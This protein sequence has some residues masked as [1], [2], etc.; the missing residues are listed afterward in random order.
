MVG[1]GIAAA[2]P[3]PARA[4]GSIWETLEGVIE[5]GN[6]WEPAD[7]I[8]SASPEGAADSPFQRAGAKADV[9]LDANGALKVCPSGAC[10]GARG[11]MCGL[12]LQVRRHGLTRSRW[13]AL[14]LAF[15][16]R[17]CACACACAAVNPNCVGTNSRNPENYAPVWQAPA[18]LSSAALAADRLATVAST[19]L[20]NAAYQAREDAESSAY[21]R[22]E[23]D[24]PW[25][26]DVVEF[27]IRDPEEDGQGPIVAYRSI[28]GVVK[29]QYP[30]QTARRDGGA[31]RARMDALR[32]AL[33][34]KLRGCDLIECYQ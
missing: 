25:A 17:A 32:D 33:G 14:A 26:R 16:A 23:C 11:G 21:L 5:A 12:R 10:A 34:W 2:R 15:P 9:G 31:Q 30:L 1:A 3:R 28:N 18:A 20:P 8:A 13:L 7:I 22:F 6:A 27:V 29:Y 4:Q 24:G 19:S